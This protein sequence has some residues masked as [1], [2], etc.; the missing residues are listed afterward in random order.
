MTI[1]FKSDSDTSSVGFEAEYTQSMYSSSSVCNKQFMKLHSL[2]TVDCLFE[3]DSDF[4]TLYLPEN[5]ERTGSYEANELCMWKIKVPETYKVF[6][7]F[8]MFEVNL[9]FH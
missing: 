3:Y 6:L 5:A 9:C 1:Q 2:F 8:E 4:G 7:H